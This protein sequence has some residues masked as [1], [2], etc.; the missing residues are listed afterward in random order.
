VEVTVAG[1]RDVALVVRDSVTV[2][3]GQFEAL[4][5]GLPRTGTGGAAGPEPLLAGLGGVTLALALRGGRRR[6]RSCRS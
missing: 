6:P 3:L 4:P 1:E 5:G 2:S